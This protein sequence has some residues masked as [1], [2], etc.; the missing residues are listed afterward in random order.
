MHA[1]ISQ[2]RIEQQQDPHLICAQLFSKA[3]FGR[4]PWSWVGLVDLFTL[5]KAQGPPNRIIKRCKSVECL[6]DVQCQAPL[7]KCKALLK[8]L[9]CYTTVRGADILRNAVVSGYVPFHQI[10]EYFVNILL[11]HY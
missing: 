5:N 10:N 11:F 9:S 4:V 6:S 8:T 7:H 1:L 2:S 3:Y